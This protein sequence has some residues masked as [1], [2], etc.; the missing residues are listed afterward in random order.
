MNKLLSMALLALD[1][2]PG[3]KRMAGGALYVLGAAATAYN[4]FGAP[5]FGT[6]LVPEEVVSGLK[7]AGSA[8]LALG[9]ATAAAR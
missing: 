1:F 9:V 5:S 6:P 3:Y 4:A 2:F 8:V 7:D